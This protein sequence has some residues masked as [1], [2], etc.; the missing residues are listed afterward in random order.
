MNTNK[1]HAALLIDLENLYLALRD[2]FE[3]ADELTVLVLQNLRDHLDQERQ[4]SPIVG[5]AYAP[6]DFSHTKELINDLALLG[7]TPVHVLAKAQKNSA[8]LML[9][10]DAMELLFTRDD[11]EM[12]VIVGGDRDYIPVVG[13]IRTH[14]RRVLV[15]SP[16]HAMSGDLLTIISTGSYLDAVEL[17]PKERRTPKKWQRLVDE[18][19]GDKQA[20]EP[21]KSPSGSQE[22]V[23]AAAK[24]SKKAIPGSLAEFEAAI[25]DKI[26]LDELKKLVTLILDFQKSHHVTEVWLGPFFRILNDAFPLKSNADRKALVNRLQ[27]LG[28]VDIQQRSRADEEGTYAVLAVIWQHPLVLELNP[29]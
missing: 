3:D 26:E 22:V 17:L 9:A 12:F 18:G 11:I 7:I 23:T 5:R 8:D 19:E 10:I 27:E 20:P 13:R 21:K 25:E 29:G 2:E 24:G 16:K 15:V 14:G 6:F 4:V 1:P 28:V